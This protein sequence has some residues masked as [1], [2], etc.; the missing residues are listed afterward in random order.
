MSERQMSS[1]AR[2]PFL[3]IVGVQRTYLEP[4]RQL[5]FP[6]FPSTYWRS[7][8]FRPVLMISARRVS[9]SSEAKAADDARSSISS[10]RDSALVFF[11]C[12]E[13]GFWVCSMPISDNQNSSLDIGETLAIARDMDHARCGTL[14]RGAV[15]RLGTMEPLVGVG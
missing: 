6:P 14:A 13:M 3:I 2:S 7:H 5:M 11:T 9:A 4:R 10:G 8:S 12:S 1:G 15:F